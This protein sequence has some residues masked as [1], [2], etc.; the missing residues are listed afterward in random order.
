MPSFN[1]E[2][3]S[4]IL[5]EAMV[6][7]KKSTCQ[8]Y[9]IPSRTY[10]Y[11]RARLRTD[12]QLSELYQQALKEL[13]QEW[14]EDSIKT[15]KKGLNVIY[16]GLNNNPLEQSP[17]DAREIEAH[18]KYLDSLSRIIKSVGD[19]AIST[20]VLKEDEEEERSRL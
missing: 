14:Q 13:K 4:Y 17:K 2:R 19:L 16:K 15:L 10:E 20:H 12:G 11:W 7:G 3:A 18:A 6:F 1:Y 8:K 9:S 5:A